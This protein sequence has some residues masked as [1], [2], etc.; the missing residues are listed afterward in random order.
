VIGGGDMR[1][2]RRG[3][4]PPGMAGA[5]FLLPVLVVALVLCHGFLGAAHVLPV[6]PEAGL[7][8]HVGTMHGG[9]GDSGNPQEGHMGSSDYAAVLLTAFVGA[10]LGLLLRGLRTRRDAGLDPFS[11]GRGALADR[12]RPDLF[13]RGLGPPVSQVFRL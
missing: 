4:V 9:H 8:S 7:A 3:D 12:G 1:A 5:R 6:G 10:A 13:L 2:L 11:A